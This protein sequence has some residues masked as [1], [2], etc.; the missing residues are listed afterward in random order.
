MTK[1][2]YIIFTF[3][4]ICVG[5]NT[6]NETEPPPYQ[7]AEYSGSP[8]PFAG[9]EITTVNG[10]SFTND[11]K[12]LYTSDNLSQK[13]TND[14]SFAGIFKRVFK[15]GQWGAPESLAFNTS[16]DAYHPVLSAD[17][18]RIFFNSRS[19]PDSTN[20]FI[21]HNIWYADLTESGWSE[22]KM[23]NYINS[24]SYDSY[25]SIALNNN[26]YFNSDRP[27][28]QGGM[29]IYMSE[30]KDGKYSTPANIEGINSP[31]SENDLVVD[32]DEKFIIFNRYI[33]SSRT[34]D[35]YVSM[36]LSNTWTQPKKLDIINADDKWE[37]TPT[38]S[39][40]KQYFFYEL[41][42][43]IMQIEL[44]VLLDITPD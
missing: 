26:L 7:L 20:V 25:P 31:F 28:G 37:L 9:G 39:P 14:R 24:S 18:K 36:K 40:D 29:D 34:L 32:P 35:M 4:L 16:I 5:C 30:Y 8:V 27:G 11:G 38:L 12:T 1:F 33:D 42:G 44:E 15:D 10:I 17:N 41:D 3:L 43:K 19:H 21:P 13:A 2:G 6:A 22:P 23:L